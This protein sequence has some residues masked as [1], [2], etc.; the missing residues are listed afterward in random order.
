MNSKVEPSL[1]A[2]IPH[3]SQPIPSHRPPSSATVLATSVSAGEA[4]LPAPI[5]SALQERMTRGSLELP[6]M[7]QVATQ[8]IAATS[9]ADCNLKL[10]A[11][12]I[13]RDQ[14]MAAH[15]LRIANSPLYAPRTKIVSLQQALGRLGMQT[16]REIALLISVKTRAFEVP[17]REAQVAELFRH[18]LGAAVYAQEIARVRRL[19]V[20]E[21]FLG[22]LLHDVGRPV[23]LQALIDL[24]REFRQPHD[25]GA[26]DGAVANLHARVGHM[27]AVKW[28]LPETV[29]HTI[30]LHHEPESAASTDK[31][32]MTASL[33][34][35]LAHA[36]GEIL[37][38]APLRVHPALAALN[39]YPEDLDGLIGLRD[40]VREIVAAVG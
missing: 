16:I 34:D 37:E 23:L 9:D 39:L 38:D 2:A 22:G 29:A 30:L 26:I 12:I 40:R 14:A 10:L 3:S 19:N 32:T 15:L 4:A 33:A 7:S 5:D 31:L 18:S 1:A 21:A 17:G 24:Y 6:V 36:H 27:L 25:Q 35:C 20:E 8:V 28:C 13:R 11:D